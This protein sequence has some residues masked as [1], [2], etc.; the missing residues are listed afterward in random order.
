MYSVAFQ[1]HA[2]NFTSARKPRFVAVS[3]YVRKLPVSTS[4]FRSDRIFSR[5]S[6]CTRVTRSSRTSPCIGLV[7]VQRSSTSPCTSARL[8]RSSFGR[9]RIAA[10]GECDARRDSIRDNRNRVDLWSC[11]TDNLLDY[12]ATRTDVGTLDSSAGGGARH[13]ATSEVVHRTRDQ[14]SLQPLQPDDTVVACERSVSRSRSLARGTRRGSEKFAL[15]FQTNSQV[16]SDA[17]NTNIINII[18]TTTKWKPAWRYAVFIRIPI[19]WTAS[20]SSFF[21]KRLLNVNGVV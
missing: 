15:H 5:S 1:I 2:S 9:Q 18:I 11:G 6:S 19:N 7:I 10:A 20:H 4:R 14:S 16:K 17:G 13:H 3:W 8:Q 21:I 12:L